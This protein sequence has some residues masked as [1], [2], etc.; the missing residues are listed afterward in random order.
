MVEPISDAHTPPLAGCKPYLEN[1]GEKMKQ[2]REKDGGLE[3]FS[4]MVHPSSLRYINVSALC[5]DE[6]ERR[7]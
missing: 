1:G 2:E 5:A 6:D 4:E 7:V 3:N